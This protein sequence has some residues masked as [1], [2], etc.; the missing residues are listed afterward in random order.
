MDLNPK[1]SDIP[2]GIHD[3]PDLSQ[4]SCV[5]ASDGVIDKNHIIKFT[6]SEGETTHDTEAGVDSQ[7]PGEDCDNMS[8]ESRSD[9]SVNSD[10]DGRGIKCTRRSSARI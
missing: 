9:A 2:D 10:R 8:F 1:K 3:T 4:E 7:S 6:S 5:C